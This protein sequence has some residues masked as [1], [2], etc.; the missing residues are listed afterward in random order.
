MN[1]MGVPMTLIRI[2]RGRGVPIIIRTVGII[3]KVGRI[4]NRQ[5]GT[6]LHTQVTLH[7]P[8][9]RRTRHGEMAVDD[10]EYDV[11][12]AHAQI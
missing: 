5:G 11:D 2:T 1:R 3:G 9:T 7:H 4:G 12:Q 10:Q 8:R 6:L